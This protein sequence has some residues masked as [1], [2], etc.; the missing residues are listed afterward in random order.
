MDKILSDFD[1][2]ERNKSMLNKYLLGNSDFCLNSYIVNCKKIDFYT[3]KQII[4]Y[5]LFKEY[6]DFV[7]L[8]TA[9]SKRA[10]F[11]VIDLILETFDYDEIIDYYLKWGVYKNLDT[12]RHLYNI[13]IE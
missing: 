3:V 10:S 7:Y 2:P 4:K 11:E 1:G 12:L 5:G 6:L 9:Y 8:R 13:S